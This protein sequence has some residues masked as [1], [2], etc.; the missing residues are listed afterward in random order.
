MEITLLDLGSL[1]EQTLN[2]ALIT[3]HMADLEKRMGNEP[4]KEPGPTSSFKPLQ[5]LP[6]KGRTA[7]SL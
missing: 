6:Y 7:L 1:V 3:S 2:M 4:V 5:T